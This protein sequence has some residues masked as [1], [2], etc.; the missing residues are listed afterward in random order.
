LNRLDQNI[1]SLLIQKRC[2]SGIGEDY[3]SIDAEKYDALQLSLQV[4]SFFP[5]NRLGFYCILKKIEQII[6]TAHVFIFS[7][8]SYE[9]SHKK[10]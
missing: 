3:T 10:R 5:T 9:Q 2:V 1:I 7:L 6:K 8:Q 4:I